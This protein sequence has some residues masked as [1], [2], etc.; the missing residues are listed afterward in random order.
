MQEYSR[1]FKDRP[2]TP[3]ES[4]VYWTEYVLKY[5]GAPFL[6]ALGTNLP[7]YQYFMLD[8]IFLGFVVTILLILVI[9]FVSKKTYILFVMISNKKST[10]SSERK[11]N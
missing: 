6:K 9:Y 7:F 2:M 10:K 11:D 8:I 4:V 1:L 5:N 3:Q